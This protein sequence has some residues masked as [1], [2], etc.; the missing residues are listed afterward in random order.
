MK[1][2]MIPSV[3][4]MSGSASS[5][6]IGLTRKFTRPKTNPVTMRIQ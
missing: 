4:T 3:I 2:R 5:F 1:N 6:T